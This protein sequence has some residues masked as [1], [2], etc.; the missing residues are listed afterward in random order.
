MNIKQ[1]FENLKNGDNGK[2]SFL[3]Q[4]VGIDI[5]NGDLFADIAEK[6]NDESILLMLEAENIRYQAEFAATE[7][8]E[9][10]RQEYNLNGLS[11][12]KYIEMI[13]EN[14]VAGM[15]AFRAARNVIKAKYP[16]PV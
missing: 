6:T 10:R 11:F 9:K 8:K 12:D 2:I 13:I 4:R 14:D 5:P 1:R 7:Y 15:D 3:A 16:K